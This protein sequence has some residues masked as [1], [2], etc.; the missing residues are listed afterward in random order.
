MTSDFL[1]NMNRL[2]ILQNIILLCVLF[3]VKINCFNLFSSY[4]S[5]RLSSPVKKLASNEDS[6]T[7]LTS[8][9]TLLFLIQKKLS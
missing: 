6:N 4:E 7:V 2:Q 5:T 1:N 3:Q 8:G 9:K